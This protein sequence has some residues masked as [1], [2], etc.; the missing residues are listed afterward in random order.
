MNRD[1]KRSA[2]RIAAGVFAVQMV[3]QGVLTLPVQADELTAPPLPTDAT[4]SDTTETTE[5]A[6]EPSEPSATEPEAQDPTEPETEAATEPET[7]ATTEQVTV[8]TDASEVQAE[9]DA[10]SISG[11]T[12]VPSTLTQGKTVA[13][14]GTVSSASTVISSLVVGI[15]NSSGQMIMG[16]TAEPNAMTYDLSQLDSALAFDKLTAGSYT[17][18]VTASN[19]SH[20]GSV[21]VSQNFT[22][23]A[24]GT[25]SSTQSGDV[26]SITNP[27]TVPDTLKKGEAFSVRG[28][29]ASAS[30]D[31]TAL[32]VGVYDEN[33]KFVTGKTIAPNVKSYDLQRLD[34]YVAFNTLSAGTYTYAV[35]ASNAANTNYAIVNKRF[36]VTDNGEA[37]SDGLSISGATEVP[38]TLKQGESFSI[39]GIVTSGSSNMT[40]LTAG[41]YDANGKFV[42]GKTIAPKATTYDLSQLDQ[43]ISFNKLP[44]GSYTFAVIASNAS[45]T[46]KA[47]VNKKF[48][49]TGAGEN[50]DT[51]SISGANDMPSTLAKGQVVR[52][53]GVVT[54]SSSTITALT[55]GVYSKDG[56]FVTGR[57]I[58]PNTKSY[59]LKNLDNYI[60]F[61]TLEEGEYVF[62]VIATNASNSN[63]ALVNKA[64]T[65]GTSSDT[66]TE[67]PTDPPAEN[68]P[69]PPAATEDKLTLTGGTAVPDTLAVGKALNVRG[70]VTS[71]NSAISSLTVGVY[72]ANNKLI[73]GRT[74][75]PNVKSYDL[76]QLDNYVEFNKLPAG[77]YVY[78]VTASNAANTSVKLYEK[79]FTVGSGTTQQPSAED[80]LSITGGMTVPATLPVGKALNVT[81]VVT[82]ESSN[83][84]AL[85]AGVYDKAG[86]FVTGKTINPNAKSYDLKKL[87]NDVAFSKLPAGEYVYAVIASNAANTN[88]ALVNQTFT[89]GDGTGTGTTTPSTND[90]L[91]IT[92]GTSVPNNLAKGKAL[93]VKGVV[94]SASSNITSLTVG[95]YDSAGKFVTGKTIAPNAKTYDTHKL[96]AYVEFNKLPEGK[97]VYAVIATNAAN[98]NYAIVNQTFS[99]GDT[100]VTTPSADDKLSISGGTTVPTQLAKGKAVSVRGVVTSANSVMTS[101]TVG[102]YDSAGKFVTGKTIDPKAK[103]YDLKHLDAY[104][105]FN[106]L[107]D[108]TYVYAVIATNAAN[109]NYALV[110]QSFTVGNGGNTGTTTPSTD[111]KLTISGG[112]T[113]PENLAKGKAVSV[114]GTVTSASSAMT[115]LTVGVYDSAGKFVTGKTINPNAKSYDLHKL[116][117]YV[118][119]NKLPEGKYVYAVIATNAANKN[120]ALVNQ[121]FTVGSGGGNTTTTTPNA[122]DKLTISGGTTVPATLAKGKALSV[123][124]TVTSASSNITALTVGVYSID[125][126]FVTGRTIAPNAKSYDLHKLDSYVEFNK[127]PA[128]KYVYAVIATNAKNSNYALVNKQFTVA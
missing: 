11:G 56:K 71:A 47:L 109:S 20:A 5:P 62:A 57:T 38:A 53:T 98:S 125:G 73:T 21:L 103:N 78:A 9:A 118:E 93:S 83:M 81:G 117:A 28:I 119:F 70:V 29:V 115:S 65:V 86:K 54:S 63:Y 37:A 41:V 100:S 44:A 1:K 30:S 114:T 76:K 72:D 85:T 112:T 52:V 106:K 108:G 110:N 23:T 16:K 61:G 10:L 75:S 15:Y 36:T 91:T 7:E 104:V 18:K 68:P 8:T 82:S 26:L 92:G 19:N 39:Q 127:L 32:T 122:D 27:S 95:V 74:A 60:S 128:G 43:Y 90:K 77:K 111:D 113:V 59:D 14:K 124:G 22:V 49:I 17:Y 31:I 6:T 69:D 42:T 51:L 102:V 80:K 3:L 101:L 126:K 105:E 94:T 88:F 25:G 99:V 84:T 116:D 48:T 120:Y 58:A 87:D 4:V 45:L 2:G 33:G 12:Q 55:A 13:V 123:T 46:N 96:D 35:I 67:N 97:Y 40:A 79:A 50:D 107:T 34:S 66:P 121:N 89:V 24:S 64:F